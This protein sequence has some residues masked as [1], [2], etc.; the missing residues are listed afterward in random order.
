[1]KNWLHVFTTR[2]PLDR[3][4]GAGRLRHREGGVPGTLREHWGLA[5]SDVASLARLIRSQL[6]ISLEEVL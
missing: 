6:P 1:V 5:T 4:R 2:R 3:Q